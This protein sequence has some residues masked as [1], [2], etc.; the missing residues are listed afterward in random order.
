MAKT[1]DQIAPGRR[2]KVLKVGGKAAANRR[3]VDMGLTTNTT[4]SVER[5]APLGDPIEIRL[6]GYN[7]SLR[8]SEAG[9]IEVEEIP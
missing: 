8:K 4:V 6:R 3:I 5:V 7:L 1:L 9:S 2:A